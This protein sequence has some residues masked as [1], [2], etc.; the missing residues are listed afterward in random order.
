MS[1]SDKCE[2]FF[3]PQDDWSEVSSDV[4]F[5]HEVAGYYHDFDDVASE[6]QAKD[7]LL[8]ALFEDFTAYEDHPD[9]ELEIAADWIV[10]DVD[11]YGHVEFQLENI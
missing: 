6:I 7:Q 9:L 11:D 4:S 10:V 1:E 5:D 8:E 2:F 3:G